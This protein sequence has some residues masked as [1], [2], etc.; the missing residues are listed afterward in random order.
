MYFSFFHH[1]E[2]ILHIKREGV[3][4]HEFQGG[5]ISNKLFELL[6]IF[7]HSFFSIFKPFYNFLPG[8]LKEKIIKIGEKIQKAYHFFQ[9]LA[10]K[11]VVK[12]GGKFEKKAHF[13]CS[14]VF[15]KMGIVFFTA[16]T[17]AFIFL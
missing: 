4:F 14:N 9:M 16:T 11:I 6:E 5:R 13:C 10:G 3:D 15:S 1:E 17:A 12:I 8:F 2:T 7:L